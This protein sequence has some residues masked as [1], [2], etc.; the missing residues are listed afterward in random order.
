[1]RLSEAG[2]KHFAVATF[3]ILPDSFVRVWEAGAAI[4]SALAKQFNEALEGLA[5][6]PPDCAQTLVC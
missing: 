2:A 1:M 4:I 5:A 6:L 3:R